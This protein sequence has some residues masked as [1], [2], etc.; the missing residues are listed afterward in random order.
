V[1]NSEV[2]PFY[3]FSYSGP[4]NQASMPARRGHISYIDG[5]TTF[6]FSKLVDGNAQSNVII[7]YYSDTLNAIRNL[8]LRLD[9]WVKLGTET[10]FQFYTTLCLEH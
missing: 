8:K 1:K 10:C 7:K 9:S 6:K 4:S 3:F 2:L 5:Y